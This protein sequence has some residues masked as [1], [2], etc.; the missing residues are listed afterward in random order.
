MRAWTEMARQ[1]AW[2]AMLTAIAV[3]GVWMMLPATM[4]GK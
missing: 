2:L 4:P 3:V 1:A